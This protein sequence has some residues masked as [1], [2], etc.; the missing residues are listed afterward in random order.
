MALAADRFRRDHD[1]RFHAFQGLYLF[2]AALLNQWVL[3]EMPWPLPHVHLYGLVETA[4]LIMS[5][6]MMVK[7]AHEQVYSL[8]LF[9]ELAARSVNKE[10]GPSPA[11]PA[12]SSWRPPACTHRSGRSARETGSHPARANSRPTGSCVCA[13]GRN[14]TECAPFRPSPI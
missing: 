14:G 6:F 7:A 11:P 13:T 8:P 5:I 2:V 4:L 12:G 10:S 9:G 3:R 1:M